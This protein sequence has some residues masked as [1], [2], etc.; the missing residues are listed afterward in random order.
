MKKKKNHTREQNI[1]TKNF[2][3]KKKMIVDN[4]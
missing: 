2:Q 1:T 3:K 4:D